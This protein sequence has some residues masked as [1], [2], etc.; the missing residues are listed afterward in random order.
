MTIV[1]RS[2]EKSDHE[3]VGFNRSTFTSGDIG[4]E[5]SCSSSWAVGP[6]MPC[7]SPRLKSPGGCLGPTPG[8]AVYNSTPSS[9]D[10]PKDQV[11]SSSDGIELPQKIL[12]PPERLSLKWNQVHRIG[13]GLQNMGNTCFL[14][15]ALQC[16]TYTP[17]LANHMLSR[18]HS[19]SCQ[20]PGFCMMCTMQNHIIQV[21]AN[22]G[23]VIKPIGVLNE[24][25]RIAKHFR[26]GSQED[27]HEFLRYTVDAMQ[28]SCLPGTKL[29]RQTQATTFIH[30]VFGGYLRS[31]VKCLS[32]K[33]VSDT[34]DPF[35]D[36][37]LEIKMAPSVSKALEQF[38]KP[39]QL[40]G[41]NAYKCTKCKK[42]VTASK[43]FTIHRSPNVLTLSL[44]RFANFTGGKITKDVKYPESLDLRP[45]MSQS[46]GEPQNYGL[47]AVL[48][49]SGFS[50][51]A[52]H[53]FCYIKASSGQWY[54]MNDSS[55]SVS[56]IR[57]VLN[58][59]AY[60]LFYIKTSDMKK[61]ADYSGSSRSPSISGQ[62]S[63]RPVV[64]PRSNAIHHNMGFIGPQLPPHA[65][66]SAVHVNGNGAHKDFPGSS[67]GTS[68]S[69]LGKPAH[70]LPSSSSSSSSSVSHSVSRPT[71]IPDQDKRQRLSFFIGQGKQNRPSSSYSQS[72]PA[73]SSGSLSSS[74]STSDIRFVPRQLNHVNGAA[75]SN[76]DQP[77]EGNGAS[78]L[79]PYSQESS[80][81]SDPENAASL[82]N[83]CLPRSKGS[84]ATEGIGATS[85]NTTNGDAGARHSDGELNGPTCGTSN[86]NGYGHHKVNGHKAPEKVSGSSSSVTAAVNGVDGGHAQPNKDAKVPSSQSGSFQN[87]QPAANES[88]R[89]QAADARAIP[90]PEPP[91]PH[92]AVS[93]P[94]SSTKPP[95][96]A[97]AEPASSSAQQVCSQ[98]SS[99]LSAAAQ[100]H[101]NHEDGGERTN[102]PAAET[103]GETGT[104]DPKA[105]SRGDDRQSTRDR[106]RVHSDYGRDR[107]RHYRDRSPRRQTDGDHY[108]YRRDYRDYHHSYRDRFPPHERSYKDW[109]PERHWDRKFFHPR[110]YDRSSRR[111]Y[112]HGHYY[113]RS[114]T[115]YDRRGYHYPHR[116]EAPGP[117]KWQQ[118]GREPRAMKDKRST[119]ERDH[120]RSRDR[121]SSPDALREPD[122]SKGSPSQEPPP[123]RD[124]HSH[125][126]E[127]CSVAHRYRKH[128]KSKK[129][130]SKDKDRHHRS[131]SSDVDS[132][133]R[134]KKRKRR[135]HRDSDPERRSSDAA[136]SRDD[137]SSDERESRKRHLD[138]SPLSEKRRRTDPS[139]DHPPPP[140]HSPPSNA[141]SYRHL[142][143]HSENGFGRDDFYSH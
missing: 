66:K 97:D 12:F 134:R 64:T 142:N 85:P 92:N 73:S 48:V 49:H 9:V 43:R 62:S 139:R 89:F 91:P 106:D 94:P 143:G 131:G 36:I 128:K 132:E 65:A 105:S 55:V 4:M 138:G 10:R 116:D 81:E 93:S 141:P 42:M 13:A 135:R 50:C 3:S 121:S 1:D 8:A 111:S 137:R 99:G 47:Y 61:V 37:T 41:E 133:S 19:K 51:H 75:C 88:Q 100:Q 31:R 82:D 107:R 40:D 78:L 29:D 30:Q 129:K 39:E 21:F 118:Y 114:D 101:G 68:S 127:D 15:S 130:K 56:D 86:Q 72:Y 69:V 83:G 122:R 25:K 71:M 70:V 20:E 126:R 136:R 28:K 108:R 58:Q 26:Y 80:E 84:G 38:V 60:V 96:A 119:W 67:K 90:L 6:T 59:Q 34:F 120:C 103:E 52:G 79:V 27:A 140:C 32:C 95:S 16:L 77:G 11:V 53:Y 112:H 104:K 46:Q 17:P 14:N 5:G 33:A 115:D 22:S 117:W 87:L 45:F 57:S 2:S 113:H 76:G 109:D 35:L 54:Q 110:E 98:S 44:K 123:K 23:N 7:D 24:L 125:K 74:H 63:P 18:E 102:G 124:D